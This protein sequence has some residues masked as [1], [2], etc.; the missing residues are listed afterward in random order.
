MDDIRAVLADGGVL[1]AACW[2]IAALLFAV[3]SSLIAGAISN[4]WRGALGAIGV[5]LAFLGFVVAGSW[6]DYGRQQAA[7]ADINTAKAILGGRWAN[8]GQT[9]AYAQDFEVKNDSRLIVSARGFL[10]FY[11][12]TKLPSG[13]IY[14]VVR[15]NGPAS[16]FFR[17]DGLLVNVEADGRRKEYIPCSR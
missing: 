5:G 9:C 6:L 16:Q 10:F 1:V 8:K 12:I 3:L 13:R 2:G 14:A 15:P 4:G 7:M 17:E 11:D